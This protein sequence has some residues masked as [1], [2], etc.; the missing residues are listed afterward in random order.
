MTVTGQTLGENLEWWEKSERRARLRAKLIELDGIDPDRVIL[1]PDRACEGRRHSPA[2]SPSSGKQPRPG[3]GAGQEHRDRPRA[4]RSRGRYFPMRA[5]CDSSPRRMPPIAAIKSTGPEAI[6]PG[7]VVVLATSAPRSSCCGDPP[8]H[9]RLEHIC[10]TDSGWSFD[11]R[12]LSPAS[13]PAPA[14]ATS[15][16]RPEQAASLGWLLE[17]DR[18]RD[19]RIDTRK[20]EGSVDVISVTLGGPGGPAGQPGAGL[21][22]PGPFPP[23]P[24]SGP[25]SKTPAAAS[26]AAAV[27]DVDRISEILEKGLALPA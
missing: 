17:G 8:G 19:P 14:S 18:V 25:R 22:L 10:P 27:F 16:P 23:I 5:R 7:D 9:L 2:R 4:A 11:R 20:L 26:G 21:G 24:V 3:G 1:A 6:Q 12:S 13:R 15:V